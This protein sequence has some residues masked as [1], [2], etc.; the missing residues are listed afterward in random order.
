MNRLKITIKRHPANSDRLKKVGRALRA[1]F[2]AGVI[3]QE[4]HDIRWRDL[5]KREQ[6]YLLTK[7]R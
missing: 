7:P 4:E 3:T 2:R 5:L 6:E 1:L